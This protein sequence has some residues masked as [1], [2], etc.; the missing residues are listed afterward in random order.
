MCAVWLQL[1]DLELSSG[2]QV[3]LLDQKL[4]PERSFMW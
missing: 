4:D 2:V 3:R 1:N